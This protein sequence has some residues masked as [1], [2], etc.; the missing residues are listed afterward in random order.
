MNDKNFYLID[1]GFCFNEKN[2]LVYL[3]RKSYNPKI[4]RIKEYK[5]FVVS[6]INNIIKSIS[7]LGDIV[8]VGVGTG[9]TI[10]AD[11]IVKSTNYNAVSFCFSQRIVKNQIVGYD[12]SICYEALKSKKVILLDDVIYTGKTIAYFT[13]LLTAHDVEVIGCISIISNKHACY[14]KKII[15]AI[16][17]DYDIGNP[18]PVYSFRHLLLG[19]GEME[20]FDNNVNKKFFNQDKEYIDLIRSIRKKDGG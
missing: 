14:D 20:E 8:L 3:R 19:E 16:E 10:I 1:D 9:G 2:L 12:Y 13:K 18:F 6:E 5:D 15:S 17:L 4:V 7:L 11:E